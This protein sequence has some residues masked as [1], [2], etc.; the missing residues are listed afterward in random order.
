M[1]SYSKSIYVSMISFHKTII[2]I[3]I[4]II[5]RNDITSVNYVNVAL[6]C[7]QTLSKIS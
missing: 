5:D 7:E 2:C 3:I 6:V 4:D 1:S